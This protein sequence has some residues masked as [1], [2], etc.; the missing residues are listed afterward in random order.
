MRIAGS[1]SASVTTNSNRTLELLPKE[2]HCTNNTQL[3]AKQS[4]PSPWFARGGLAMA[5]KATLAR[6]LE[7][8]MHRLSNARPYNLN[9]KFPGSNSEQAS[10]ETN[11]SPWQ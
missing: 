3:P 11:V 7:K 10:S 5:R 1:A 8:R 4:S 6:F 9:E 2:N